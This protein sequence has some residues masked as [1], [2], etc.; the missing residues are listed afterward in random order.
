LRVL[1]GW[2]ERERFAIPSAVPVG[3]LWAR[4]AQVTGLQ[5]LPRLVGDVRKT[6]PCR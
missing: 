3:Q 5:L 6:V 4:S 1:T 2:V